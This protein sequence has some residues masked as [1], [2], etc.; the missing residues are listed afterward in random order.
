MLKRNG[1]IMLQG[2]AGDDRNELMDEDI[3]AMSI[4]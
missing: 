3:K 4:E 2:R 1:T